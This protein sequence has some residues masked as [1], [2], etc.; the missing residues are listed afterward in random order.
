MNNRL[1]Y[2]GLVDTRIS[3]SEKDL[4]VLVLIINLFFFQIIS[5][6]SESYSFLT[7]R[8]CNDINKHFKVYSIEQCNYAN[9]FPPHGH[10]F[11]D[12]N[13]GTGGVE[14]ISFLSGVRIIR[15]DR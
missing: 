2:C 9:S 1:K 8:H 5:E 6:T 15:S 10:I 3:A 12:M 14:H 7:R 13:S 11:G 4:P